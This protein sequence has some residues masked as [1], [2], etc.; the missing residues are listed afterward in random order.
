MSGSVNRVILIGNLTRDPEPRA[1]RGGGDV[2]SL[3]LAV[4]D[5]V[6]DPDTGRW[7]DRANYFDVDVFGGLGENCRQWLAK[8]RQVAIEG[9]LR[10]REWE[11]SDGQKRSMVSVIAD[12][13]QFL[14]QR[15][16]QA[17]DDAGMRQGEEIPRKDQPADDP[18]D[19]IPF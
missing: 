6:K 2:C 16:I 9:R 18:D 5:S 3:R 19:D 13:V 10:W 17:R 7:C 1:M 12:K 14:G 4:N 8:G 11:T 15:E